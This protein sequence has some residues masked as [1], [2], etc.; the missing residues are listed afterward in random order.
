MFI[1]FVNASEIGENFA[2]SMIHKSISCLFFL[3]EVAESVF[4][5]IYLIEA[6]VK[7]IAYGFIL[8][9]SAYLRN[10]WNILDF[11]VVVVG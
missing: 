3:Q 9:P 11:V 10:G 7:I 1:F 6:V 4:V 2:T 5:I 8:H